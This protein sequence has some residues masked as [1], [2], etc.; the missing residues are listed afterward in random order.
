MI[1]LVFDFDQFVDC[2]NLKTYF[3]VASENK[4]ANEFY[5][6]DNPS[7]FREGFRHAIKPPS[8]SLFDGINSLPLRVKQ[9]CF[10][11]VYNST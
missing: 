10:S 4:R 7:H 5:N 1:L 8:L 9:G 6:V 11:K 2:L 3:R